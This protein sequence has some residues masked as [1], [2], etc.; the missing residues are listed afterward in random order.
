MISINVVT[1]HK[2][3]NKNNRMRLTNATLKKKKKTFETN[4]YILYLYVI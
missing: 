3:N 2:N 4:D 1:A